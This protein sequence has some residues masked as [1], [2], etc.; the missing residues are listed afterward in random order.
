[1]YLR[2]VISVVGFL[3]VSFSAFEANAQE[4]GGTSWRLVKIMSMDDSVA[5]PDDPSKYTLEFGA[6]GTASIQADCNRGTGSWTSGSA[7][8]L[9]FGLIA[10]TR[11]LCP[12]G[13]LSEKY[14][15]QFE[16]VRSYV[17][18]GGNLFLATMADGAIIEFEPIG[19]P[20]SAAMVLGEEIF[21]ADA[22][23]MQGV[24]LAK[25]FDD[26]AIKHSIEVEDV[27]ID[28]FAE[29]MRRG[30][31]EQGL[32]A[33]K[34][35]T[36][37]EA[38][39]VDTMRRNMAQSLIRQWKINK[40]LYDEYGG[41]IIYQQFGPEPLD[42]YRRFLEQRLKEG[43]FVIHDRS[44]AD[45]FWRYFKD[46]SIHDFMEPGSADEARAFTIPPWDQKE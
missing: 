40:A 29:N 8:Q 16:W 6:D 42:A 27:E 46:E 39:E 36:P 21:T 7:S 13:S 14:L 18:E 28:A 10:S 34:D 5:T 23:E 26:Y 38:A 17:K 31:A 15:A 24:I 30:L 45:S 43:A 32:T 33:E 19:Q 25:L 3:F 37:Q 20:S 12:P 41:R 44:L 22:A 35:L 1:M 4:L 11:A 2:H 9:Q